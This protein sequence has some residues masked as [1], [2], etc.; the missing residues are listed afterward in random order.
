MPTLLELCEIDVPDAV[1]GVSLAPHML[2][3][4]QQ[5]PDSV[6]LQILG[7]GWPTRDKWLGLWRAVR[8]RDYVYARWHDLGG[9]RMLFNLHR[10]PAEMNNLIDDPKAARIA[11][12][13]EGRLQSWLECTRDPFDTGERLPVTEMLDLG[14]AFDS[15]HWLELAPA[16]YAEAIKK[17]HLNFKTG[18]QPNDP[19]VPRR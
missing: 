4:D 3:K 8:T 9:Q 10:D 12:E 6:F 7:P 2:G 14:Q 13:M 16:A 1:Q 17:N 19:R 18:E 5:T 15:T 11:D